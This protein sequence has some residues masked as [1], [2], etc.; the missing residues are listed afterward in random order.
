MHSMLNIRSL[1]VELIDCYA[2]D[3]S[4]PEKWIPLLADIVSGAEASLEKMKSLRESL[5]LLTEEL[6]DTKWVLGI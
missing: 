5:D 4:E 6:E 1:L 2:K 3:E